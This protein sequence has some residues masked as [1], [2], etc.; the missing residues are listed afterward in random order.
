MKLF[1]LAAALITSPLVFSQDKAEINAVLEKLKAQGVFSESDVKAAQKQ[2][3]GMSDNEVNSLV[4][5]GKEKINDPNIQ[6]KLKEF[7]N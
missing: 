4:K 6:K 5:K 1:L 3:N 2:L 7:K